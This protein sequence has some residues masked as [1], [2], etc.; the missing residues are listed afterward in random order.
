MGLFPNPILLKERYAS[1]REL[2]ILATSENEKL[3]LNSNLGKML[4][5]VEKR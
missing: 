5:R 3:A 2:A 1:L 4:G